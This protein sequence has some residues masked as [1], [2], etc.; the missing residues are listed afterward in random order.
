MLD[1][2]AGADRVPGGLP[3][4]AR[5]AALRAL[6]G[7]LLRSELYALDGTDRAGPPVHGHRVGLRGP[8]G[9][10]LAGTGSRTSG[11]AIF[12]PFP[13][14]SRTTQWERG[15]EP[16]TRFTFPAG[17]D[18]YGFA[19]RGRSPSPCPAAVTRASHDR[20]RG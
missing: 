9:D 17:Y 4:S 15:D 1:P 13:L 2:P 16:M 5:R 6:R 7:Q 10:R 12:F 20:R 19:D 18:A 8:R 3:R 14:G 11:N